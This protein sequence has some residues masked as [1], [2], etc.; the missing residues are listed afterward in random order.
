MVKNCGTNE[1]LKGLTDK[2]KAMA[3]TLNNAVNLD[4]L[5]AFKAKA[6]GI[7]EEVKGKLVS[8][9][10]KPKNLQTELAALGN[11]GDAISVGLAVAAIEKDFGKGLG[12]GVLTGALKNIVPPLLQGAAGVIQGAEDALSGALAGAGKSFDV[13]K[14]VPNLEIDDSGEPVEKAKVEAKAAGPAETP[15]KVE[16]TIVDSTTEP[17]I[18]TSKYTNNEYA[19]ANADLILAQIDLK[20]KFKNDTKKSNLGY[21]KTLNKFKGYLKKNKK[22][23]AKV[24]KIREAGKKHA[25]NADLFI[26]GEWPEE[27]CPFSLY[28]EGYKL[29]ANMLYAT[30][31]HGEIGDNNTAIEGGLTY[32]EY[33]GFHPLFAFDDWTDKTKYPNHFVYKW[34]QNIYDEK[35][36]DEKG[37]GFELADKAIG[38]FYSEQFDEF[39]AFY[40]RDDIKGYIEIV[41]DYKYAGR[42]K[43]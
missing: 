13:C 34:Y 6:E 16:P 22:K 32:K 15:P 30:A 40:D 29:Q 23:L 21:K 42:T 24:T 38:D 17:S 35:K 43:E 7:A 12:A 39:L 33:H 5:E 19:S 25:T 14:N 27:V 3:D 26:A 31:L 36:R 9:I 20:K 11:L 28:K 18:G 8:Q 10:P 4:E 1:A 2:T 37:Y 41:T